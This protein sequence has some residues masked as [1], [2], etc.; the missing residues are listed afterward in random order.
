M[1]SRRDVAC[2]LLALLA[3]AVFGATASLAN[4]LSSPFGLGAEVPDGV[5][6]TARVVSLALGPVYAWVLLPL[7]LGWVQR[8]VRSAAAGGALGVAAAVL[9]YYVSDALLATGLPLDLSD[10]LTA[11][12]LWTAV[13][14][15]GGAL[16]GALAGAVRRR[17]SA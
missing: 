7:P 1:P 8:G 15:P 2:L 3:G 13:G 17:R 9:A 6:S 11:L 12:A 16:L 5:R 4:D 10:D 14:V